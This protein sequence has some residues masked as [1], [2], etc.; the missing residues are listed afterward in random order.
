MRLLQ[1]KKKSMSKALISVWQTMETITKRPRTCVEYL[2]SSLNIGIQD[3]RHGRTG[4]T[5]DL[6]CLYCVVNLIV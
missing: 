2:Y 3:S 4:T 5:R 6:D 1:E